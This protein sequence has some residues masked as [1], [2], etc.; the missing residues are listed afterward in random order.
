MSTRTGKVVQTAHPQF[1]L[2]KDLRRP[3]DDPKKHVIEPEEVLRRVRTQRVLDDDLNGGN[4]RLLPDKTAIVDEGGAIVVTAEPL[5]LPRHEGNRCVTSY[6]TDAREVAA[7]LVVADLGS[8]WRSDGPSAYERKLIDAVLRV[9]RTK[10]G[11][12]AMRD[13]AILSRPDNAPA[14]FFYLNEA[15]AAAENAHSAPD[16]AA[17]RFNN[18]LSLTIISRR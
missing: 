1:R 7:E 2:T 6:T 17:L 4:L 14:C 13:G 18:L 10:D 16:T 15:R 11:W 9:E 12:I 8:E 3:L 5:F